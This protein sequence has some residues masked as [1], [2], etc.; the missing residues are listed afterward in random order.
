[1]SALRGSR[2]FEPHRGHVCHWVFLFY[3]PFIVTGK[4]HRRRGNIGRVSGTR[5]AGPAPTI[6]EIGTPSRS[7]SDHSRDRPGTGHAPTITLVPG[8]EYQLAGDLLPT[9]EG[10]LYWWEHVL[11]V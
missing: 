1:M 4:T 3:S 7:D 9:N 6:K 5:W 8:P 11:G 2:G 10:E